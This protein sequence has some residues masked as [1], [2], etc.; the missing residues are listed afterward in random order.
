MSSV[1]SRRSREF[2]QI[3]HGDEVDLA[4]V[5]SGGSSVSPG[6]TAMQMRP[7]SPWATKVLT[8]II[9]SPSNTRTIAAGARVQGLTQG[10]PV[11]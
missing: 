2:L 8:E 4:I 10:Y 9:R 1:A 5:G 11:G 3:L 7:G 6:M